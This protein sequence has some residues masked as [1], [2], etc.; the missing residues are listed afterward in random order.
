MPSC[1]SHVKTHPSGQQFKLI[2][3]RGQS[4]IKR[5]TTAGGWRQGGFYGNFDNNTILFIFLD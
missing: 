1:Q 3:G 2:R 5:D 4:E